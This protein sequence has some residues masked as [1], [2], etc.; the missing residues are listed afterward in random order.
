MTD[1]CE[2]YYHQRNGGRR[3]ELVATHDHHLML[4]AGD[5]NGHL[6]LVP[7]NEGDIRGMMQALQARLE[8]I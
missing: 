2:V 3:V 6:V 7:L 1:D 5:P 8:D 4:I